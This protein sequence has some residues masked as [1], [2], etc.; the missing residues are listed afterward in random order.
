MDKDPAN[1]TAK[2]R[3]QSVRANDY[4]LDVKQIFKQKERAKSWKQIKLIWFQ[5]LT[6]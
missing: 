4:S 3:K 6:L 2:T 5:S 1:T